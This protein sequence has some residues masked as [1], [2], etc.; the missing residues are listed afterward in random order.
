MHT[1]GVAGNLAMGGGGGG[2]ILDR[3][4]HL[5]M[6][7]QE[8]IIITCA[9]QQKIHTVINKTLHTWNNLLLEAVSCE[10]IH[11]K[12]YVHSFK[13]A[14]SPLLSGTMLTYCHCTQHYVIVSSYI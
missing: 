12:I 7:K 13:T 2:K 11:V 4:P 3:K 8:V 14:V 10:D 1:R 6:Q 5:L 9:F